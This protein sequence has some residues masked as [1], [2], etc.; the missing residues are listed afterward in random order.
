VYINVCSRHSRSAQIAPPPASFPRRF[1]CQRVRNPR[2]YFLTANRS[3]ERNK[4]KRGKE[5][6]GRARERAMW[7]RVARNRFTLFFSPPRKRYN[8]RY[9]ASPSKIHF[10]IH[11]NIYNRYINNIAENRGG[12]ASG[13]R[14]DVFLIKQISDLRVIIW[15]ISILV[16]YLQNN[17]AHSLLCIAQ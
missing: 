13:I 15:M 6:K 9:V 7:A 17:C 10:T 3:K 4:A 8:L 11:T 1:R 12:T 2:R 14:F 5:R 16:G